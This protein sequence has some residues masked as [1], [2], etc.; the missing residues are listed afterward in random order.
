MIG[1]PAVAVTEN[2]RDAGQFRRGMERPSPPDLPGKKD[3]GFS[4]AVNFSIGRGDAHFPEQ[5]RGRQGKK[6]LRSR[7]LQRSEAE[8]ARLERAAE[9]P[10][11]RSADA[12]VAVEE[13]PAARGATSFY[14]SHF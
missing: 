10:G 12:A 5:F 14:I 11:K 3:D 9:A 7:I 13:N 4:T 8:P 1:K 6:G 2:P